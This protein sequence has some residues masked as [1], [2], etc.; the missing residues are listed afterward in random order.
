MDTRRLLPPCSSI[1]ISISGRFR[2]RFDNHKLS[3]PIQSRFLVNIDISAAY[4]DQ[5]IIIHQTLDRIEV[6]D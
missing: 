5:L 4:G 3:S 1:S 2:L 6:I